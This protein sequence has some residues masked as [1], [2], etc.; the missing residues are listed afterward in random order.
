MGTGDPIDQSFKHP[1]L[2][3]LHS[4]H[5]LV[6]QELHVHESLEITWSW[7]IGIVNPGTIAC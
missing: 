2:V 7:S 3:L 4:Y 6:V 5:V 1:V